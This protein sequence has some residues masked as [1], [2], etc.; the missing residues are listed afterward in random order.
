MTEIRKCLCGGNAEVF[1]EYEGDAPDH[2]GTEKVYVQC[3]EC[4]IRTAGASCNSGW[5]EN[6]E[7]EAEKSE[8]DDWNRFMGRELS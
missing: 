4:G 3:T 8:I 1:H 2:Y 6:D 7:E 5:M